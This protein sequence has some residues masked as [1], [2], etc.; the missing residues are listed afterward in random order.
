[1]NLL[2][3][4]FYQ[5]PWVKINN[6]IFHLVGSVGKTERLTSFHGGFIVLQNLKLILAF[7]HVK[8]ITYSELVSWIQE[9]AP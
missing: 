1:M 4:L 6:V 8:K 5:V 3:Y 7:V 9:S 2:K